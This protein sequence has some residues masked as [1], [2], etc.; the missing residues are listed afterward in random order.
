[1]ANIFDKIKTEFEDLLTKHAAEL[2][3]VTTDAEKAVASPLAQ[4]AVAAVH[5]PPEVT[6]IVQ[7]VLSKL[8]AYFAKAVPASAP[9]AT[10]T[11][12]ASTAPATAAPAEGTGTP[13]AVVAQQASS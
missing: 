11:T 4:A 12:V 10:A 3:S 1:M 8:D 5:L 2:E 7:E 9:P 6:S 13:A